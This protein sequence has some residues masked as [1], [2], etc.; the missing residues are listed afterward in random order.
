MRVTFC[1]IAMYHNLTKIENKKLKKEGKIKSKKLKKEGKKGRK[2]QKTTQHE[3]QSLE[4]VTAA[5]PQ[6]GS[7]DGLRL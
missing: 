1:R 5:T 6:L 7:P 4:G 2:T 3:R